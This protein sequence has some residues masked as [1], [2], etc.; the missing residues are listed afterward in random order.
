[1]ELIAQYE[2]LTARK[3]E[4][5]L[6]LEDLDALMAWLQPLLKNEMLISASVCGRG[7]QYR[8]N[9]NILK[10]SEYKGQTS[11]RRIENYRL[12]KLIL[13]DLKLY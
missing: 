6:E 8:L 11:L 7:V 4:K 1:M 9:P 12:K 13:E 10:D 3:L 5:Y 2:N